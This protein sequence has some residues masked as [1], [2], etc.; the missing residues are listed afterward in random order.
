MSKTKTKNPNPTTS[1]QDIV[2]DLVSAGI[3]NFRSSYV[4]SRTGLEANVV[5]DEL[6]EMVG[7]NKLK[8]SFEVK[9]PIT[10]KTLY[11]FLVPDLISDVLKDEL[12]NS[13]DVSYENI[14]VSF[15]A[16]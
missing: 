1:V 14:I 10:G 2:E 8:A 6:F 11:M 12:G 3:A 15:S 7:E 13:F 9:S 5:I 16:V 4:A